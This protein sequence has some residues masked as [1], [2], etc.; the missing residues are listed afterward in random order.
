MKKEDRVYLLHVLDAVRRIQ[1]YTK[2]GESAFLADEK[3]QDAGIRNFEVIGEAAKNLS[4][5]L[6]AKHP[7][8]AWK[9]VAGMRDK[10]IH[11]YFGVKLQLVWRTVQDD[12]PILDRTIESILQTMKRGGA[13]R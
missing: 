9:D 4:E 12:L 8:I 2:D 13:G 11:Q 5:E 6:K 3:T 1:G 10:L 7:G